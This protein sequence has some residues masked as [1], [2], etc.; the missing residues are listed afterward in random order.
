MA[1]CPPALSRESG[2]HLEAVLTNYAR[3]LAST[4]ECTEITLLRQKRPQHFATLCKFHLSLIVDLPADFSPTRIG[5]NRLQDGGDSNILYS[6]IRRT[7]AWTRFAQLPQASLKTTPN[8]VAE[9]QIPRAPTVG[10][11]DAMSSKDHVY[12][13]V[14]KLMDLLLQDDYLKTEGIFRKTGNV[15]RQR[16]LRRHI[17]SDTEVELPLTATTGS[18][19]RH[20]KNRYATTTV[21]FSNGPSNK[22]RPRAGESE[23]N[24]DVFN[25]H[26]YAATLKNV[27]H[28]MPEPILTRELLPVFSAVSSLTIG[29]LDDSGNR[30]PL[31]PLDYKVAVAKQLKALRIL[32][33]LLPEKNQQLLRQFLDLLSRTLQLSH[34]NKMSADNL[35]TVFGPPL[36]A[37][38]GTPVTE[39]HRQ[40]ANLGRLASLMIEQG[41]TSIFSV[42]TALAEDVIRNLPQ[43]STESLASFTRSLSADSGVDSCSG[44]STD[45]SQPLQLSATGPVLE[46][47]GRRTVPSPTSS[48]V[49]YTG[50][51][52]AHASGG[53]SCGADR[54]P[55]S[56]LSDTEFAVAELCATVQALPDTDP[57]K[58]CLIQRINNSNGGLTPALQAEYKRLRDALSSPSLTPLSKTGGS[59]ALSR[60]GGRGATRRKASERPTG[61]L[62]KRPCSKYLTV[63]RV[64]DDD[65]GAAVPKD[66]EAT[67]SSTSLDS[68]CAP[69]CCPIISV[70]ASPFRRPVHSDIARVRPI[71]RSLEKV[72]SVAPDER[73][74]VFEETGDEDY[75]DDCQDDGQEYDGTPKSPIFSGLGINSP[76]SSDS[77]F[78]EQVEFLRSPII[79]GPVPSPSQIVRRRSTCLSRLRVRRNYARHTKG[80]HEPRVPTVLQQQEQEQRHDYERSSL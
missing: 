35:G 39:F 11:A 31:S 59:G 7:R 77:E 78:F 54:T 8:A 71:K 58:L 1:G 51:V 5:T 37:P 45:I 55:S 24:G 56:R 63:L 6:T 53:G 80:Y 17:L 66:G 4:T 79:C 74:P 73:H 33:L 62:A 44:S 12:Q 32:R 40:Y 27:L 23:P 22:V 57:R 15:V 30:V 29:N 10:L 76:V 36:L 65:G 52:Y 25:A 20:R 46:E 13:N 19:R 68:R 47:V 16:E 18:V 61:I 50:V 72:E 48:I 70:L 49:I 34:L 14:S 26:D 60:E 64:T 69:F 43:D 38:I 3:R 67:T 41:S 42:P 28:D 75:F 9:S 2:R 21:N